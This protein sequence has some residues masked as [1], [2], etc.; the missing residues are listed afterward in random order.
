MTA[1]P[2][3]EADLLLRTFLDEEDESRR[4]SL[5]EDII[6]RFA[7]PIIRRVVAS[8]FDLVGTP[9]ALDDRWIDR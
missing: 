3:K 7:R 1:R 6:C 8:V 4:D 2:Q 9:V 5:L